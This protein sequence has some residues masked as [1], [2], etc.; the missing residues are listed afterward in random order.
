MEKKSYN[1]LNRV[2][3]EVDALKM[4]A[5]QFPEVVEL[6]GHIQKGIIDVMN[7]ERVN[8]GPLPFAPLTNGMTEEKAKTIAEKVDDRKLNE[9]SFLIGGPLP[10]GSHNATCEVGQFRVSIGQDGTEK[11]ANHGEEMY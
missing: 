9:I 3:G 1:N 7:T 11:E 8:D 6:C 5:K 4:L 2:L 10:D